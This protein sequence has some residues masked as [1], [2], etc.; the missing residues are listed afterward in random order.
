VTDRGRSIERAPLAGILAGT[1][2]L[3]VFLLLHQLWITPIWFVAPVGVVMAAAG[4]AAVGAA[5]AEL[6]PRLPG[7]PWTPIVVASIWGGILL[8]AIVL[9]QI[10]GPI[11]STEADGSGVLL[12]PGTEA[13]A[14]VVGLFGLTAVAGA[15]VGGVI[16]RS[17]RAAALTM[18]AAIGLAVG[19]GHNIPLLGGS[20][21]VGK[22]LAIL[23][24]VLGVATVV[25]VE[26]Q[27][28]L[29]AP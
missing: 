1:A 9:A 4:G 19:P 5:H 6:M 11:F 20:A 8:P 22:E 17:R 26:A 13:L 29:T 28:R 12:V 25:L 10:R 18:L 2:A 15:I 27:A 7:R 24:A 3:A 21:A 14:I 23:G 16:G